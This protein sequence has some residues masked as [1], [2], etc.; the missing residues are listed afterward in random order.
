MIIKSKKKVKNQLREEA[1]LSLIQKNQDRM[2]KI[3][4][5]YVKNKEDALDVV[6]EAVYKGYISYDKVKKVEYEET[7]L[8]RILINAAIDFIKKK[9]KIV[10]LELGQL[11]ELSS[12]DNDLIDKK[13]AVHEALDK[14]TEHEKAIVILRYFEDMKLMD[15]AKLLGKPISTIKSTLYRALKKIE[16]ELSEVD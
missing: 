6:Q 1:F 7:W 13:I 9:R 5:S 4:Y 15:V 11:E 10:T 8:I 12:P 3:A 2:Y 14:L 16:I